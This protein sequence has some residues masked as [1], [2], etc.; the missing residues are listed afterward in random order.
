[1]TF[2]KSFKQRITRLQKQGVTF[3]EAELED[4]KTKLLAGICPICGKK[5]PL[6]KLCIDHCHKT[7]KYRG[8]ICVGCNMY[9]G[10]LHDNADK[11]E[12]MAKYLQN[13]L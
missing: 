13:S 8:V 3:S 10:M 5:K 11:L 9:I 7:K 2:E 6:S 1:M 12:R 4:I